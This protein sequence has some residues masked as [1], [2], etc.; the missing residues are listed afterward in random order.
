MVTS[1]AWH[2]A[3]TEVAYARWPPSPA[4]A[5]TCVASARR[6]FDSAVGQLRDAGCEVVLFGTADPGDLPVLRHLRTKFA[7]FNERLNEVAARHECTVIEL[8][9]LPPLADA[10]AWSADRLH[11]SA[12]G[13][14]LVALYVCA[15]LGV[16]V[17][18][19]WRAPWPP[20]RPIP[21]W[22]RRYDDAR[23]AKDH[24]MPWVA[25]RLRRRSS[26]DE[27]QAKRPQLQPL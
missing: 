3:P 18:E 6:V 2:S 15:Q 17:D 23:W 14:R 8:W 10:R 7:R 9:R 13:H 24:L 19:D 27:F 25:R 5:T 22:S 16:D 11:L 26:G 12:E 4:Q 20:A 1:A 21:W